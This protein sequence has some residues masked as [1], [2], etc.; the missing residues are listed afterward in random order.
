MVTDLGRFRGPRF[1][2]PV[3]GALDQFSARAAN[4]LAGNE[5]NDAL[6]EI[7]ALD[8]RLRTDHRHPHRRHRSAA[9]PCHVGGRDLPAVGTGL[10]PGRRNPGGPRDHRRAPRLPGRP[11]LGR[12]T[13]PARKLRPG[14]RRRLRPRTGGR[15]RTETSPQRGR[16]SASRTSTCRCSGWGSTRPEFGSRARQWTSPTARTST[17]SATRPACCSPPS[18]T[19]S[20]RSNHIGLRLG[21]ELPGTAVD[22]R[23][24][25]PRRSGRGRRG[26]V[27]GRTPG[28]AP[29]PRSH[30]RLSGPGRGDQHAPW[31]SWPRPGR[32]TR[33]P[34]A[35]TTVAEAAASPPGGNTPTRKP[36]GR[37]HHGVRPPRDRRPAPL[38]RSG[39]G[40]RKLK[41]LASAPKPCY[42]PLS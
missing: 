18:Y 10:G 3:N 12:G 11:R 31:T 42:P 22:R 16:R 9:S 17:S 32:A 2:L 23:S 14:H 15:D 30:R 37:R 27:P 34:S 41:T 6:L 26:P 4:I 40:S 20:G 39:P 28:P 38:A 21:G 8:F 13:R 19:V 35:R 1:G 29:R 24:A 36:P 25:L 5:D 7:T 33:S